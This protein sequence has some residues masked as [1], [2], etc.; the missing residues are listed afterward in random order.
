MSDWVS[1]AEIKS[2]VTLAQVLRSYQVDWLRRSGR[3]SNIAGAVRFTE[4]RGRKPFMRNLERGLFHCFACGAGGNVLD[5]VAAMEG[6]SIREAALRLQGSSRRPL[7]SGCR[8]AEKPEETGYEK[9]RSQP[10]AGF[11]SGC[12]SPASLLGPARD[13]PRTA[14]TSAWDISAAAD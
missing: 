8:R 1:F 6:C 14:D 10:A 13:R 4:A 2:R 7:R 3:C 11:L 9:K 5:F 12:G